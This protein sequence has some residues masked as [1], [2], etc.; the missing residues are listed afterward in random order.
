MRDHTKL[1]AFELSD[2]LTLSIYRITKSFPKS[3]TFGLT[4]QMRRAAVSA[5]SNIV[6]GCSRSSQA[7]FLRFLEIALGSIREL[8]YQ[9]SLAF[10]L[11]YIKE[12]EFHELD[13]K[14]DESRKVLAGLIL[15]IRKGE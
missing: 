3:E 2:E 4:S 6:E 11:T 12:D 5:A 8:H 7:D 1:K 14:C 9:L 15:K 10:R 13:K